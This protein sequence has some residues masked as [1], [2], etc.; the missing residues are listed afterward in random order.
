MDGKREREENVR[1]SFFFKATERL[2]RL[3]SCV[4]IRK[5]SFSLSLSAGQSG[6]TVWLYMSNDEFIGGT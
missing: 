3:I 4:S 5:H 2:Q 1:S 6:S